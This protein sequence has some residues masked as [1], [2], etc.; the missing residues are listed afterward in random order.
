MSPIRFA[1]ITSLALITI[2][3]A[4]QEGDRVLTTQT[5]VH[6]DSKAD[7]IPDATAIKL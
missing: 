7:V 2:A 5:L 1:L 3:A 6:A 4:A